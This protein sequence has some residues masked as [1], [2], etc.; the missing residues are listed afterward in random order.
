MVMS[1]I[2]TCRIFAPPGFCWGERKI[3]RGH[4]QPTAAGILHMP[5]LRPQADIARKPGCEP[6]S[7]GRRLS[8]SSD[9]DA[10]T[11][12]KESETEGA[13]LLIHGRRRFWAIR[14][15]A[16]N[17]VS[18]PISGQDFRSLRLVTAFE[19]LDPPGTAPFRHRRGSPDL[20]HRHRRAIGLE[21]QFVLFAISIDR[22]T[23]D[24]GKL[25]R[26]EASNLLAYARR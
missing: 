25:S 14:F 5:A 8:P 13:A 2:M 12:L 17:N 19:L 26:R 4:W 9:I 20:S 16:S 1:P 6:Q 21:L 22:A 18:G 10:R 15:Q 24:A 11:D 23:G 3:H 7:R